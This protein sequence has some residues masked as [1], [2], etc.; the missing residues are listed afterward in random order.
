LEQGTCRNLAAMK[1]MTS[2]HGSAGFTLFELLIVITISGIFA[3]IGTASF[4]YL[5]TSNRAST[6]INGL[7][8]DLQY[9]RSEA[10]KEGQYVTVCPANATGTGCTGSNNW[11]T[12]WIIFV[13]LNNNQAYNSG[14][15][16]AILRWQKTISPDVL[17]GSAAAMKFV[18]FNR[19]GFANPGVAASW[20]LLSLNSTPANAQ[21]KRC[22]AISAVGAI[23]VE[24]GGDTSP[25]SC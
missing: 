9:A 24:K 23:R 17:Q 3:A 21:W 11:S 6:E 2:K 1:T 7:L 20:S 18:T 12:G 25:T 4:K 10:Q 19:E 8:N 5:T 16:G 15:E 13:D 22:I 14:S